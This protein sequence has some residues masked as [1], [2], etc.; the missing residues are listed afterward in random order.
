MYNTHAE[1][2]LCGCGILGM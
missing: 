1:S 2:V